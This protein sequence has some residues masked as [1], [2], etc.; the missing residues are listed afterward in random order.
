MLDGEFTE[1]EEK[2][3]ERFL[4]LEYLAK[5]QEDAWQWV[6]AI[7]E[8]SDTEKQNRRERE[9]ENRR[10]GEERVA[11]REAILEIYARASKRVFRRLKNFP[12]P[13]PGCHTTETEED[14]E[15]P[16]Y[17]Q[18]HEEDTEEVS[19]PPLRPGRRGTLSF[20]SRF[21]QAYHTDT[22]P[23]SPHP[24]TPL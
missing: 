17:Y 4:E 19:S 7:D 9:M 13:V 21:R 22:I 12:E 24:P 3:K 14:D 18:Q 23:H 10:K 2:L 1:R 5:E 20:P 6:N 11:E 16:R 15:D 8:E